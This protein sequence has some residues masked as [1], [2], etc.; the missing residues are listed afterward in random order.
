MT[1]M[2]KMKRKVGKKMGADKPKL[3]KSEGI[4]TAKAIERTEQ[5]MAPGNHEGLY[6]L[7]KT[8]EPTFFKS[9]IERV[10]GDRDHFR[11]L[12]LS[13]SN[14]DEVCDAL[15][16]NMIRGLLIYRNAVGLY[17]EK[18]LEEIVGKDS[19]AYFDKLIDDYLAK[20]KDK[21]KEPAKKIESVE[22][23]T[24]DRKPQDLVDD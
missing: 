4:V 1:T 5:Q 7:L 12:G 6:Y 17:D 13:G 3:T 19:E 11:T 15:S 16:T 9:I 22:P 20:K 21:E 24:S 18:K 10:K 8:V 2:K 14:L 23:D